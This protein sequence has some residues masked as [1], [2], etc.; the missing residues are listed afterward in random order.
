MNK[1]RVLSPELEDDIFTEYAENLLKNYTPD[2]VSLEPY[3]IQQITQSALSC[4]PE[5][6]EDHVDL[7]FDV[8]YEAISQALH[9]A[10]ENGGGQ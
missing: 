7:L 9:E 6:L 5:G 3:R 10:Q 1:V 4:L 8:I 2:T